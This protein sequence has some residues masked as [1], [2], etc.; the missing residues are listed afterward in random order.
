MLKLFIHLVSCPIYG[1]CNTDI[2]FNYLVI[3]K[4][5]TDSFFIMSVFIVSPFCSNI[6]VTSIISDYYVF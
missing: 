1:I 5:G 6:Y 2:T 4:F 3:P